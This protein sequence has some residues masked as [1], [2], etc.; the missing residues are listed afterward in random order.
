MRYAAK[1]DAVE[2]AIVEALT[3]AGCVVAKLSQAGVGDLLVKR[4]DGALFL[5]ECKG[6]RGTLTPAQVTFRKA[7]GDVPLV[8]TPAAALEAVGANTLWIV[9]Y[10]EMAATP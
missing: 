1:R 7:W 6:R 5:L 2:P 4:Q 10:R 9:L 3:R 8:R